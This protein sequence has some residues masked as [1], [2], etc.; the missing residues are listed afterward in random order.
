MQHG[1]D[2]ANRVTAL[3]YPDGEVV[4]QYY[5]DLFNRSGEFMAADTSL[6]DNIVIDTSYQLPSGSP[7]SITFGN[8]YTTTY[9]DDPLYRLS[10][11]KTAIG[12]TTVQDLT[13]AYQANGNVQSINDAVAS[14]N[15]S[16]SYDDLDRLTGATGYT[17]GFT[18]SYS[19]N[20]IGNLLTAGKLVDALLSERRQPAPCGDVG[21]HRGRSDVRH[22]HA[23]AQPELRHQ[24]RPRRQ[25]RRRTRLRRRGPPDR[26]A[27][28]DGCDA[29]DGGLP[30]RRS[31][32]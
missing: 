26:G 1:Y 30:L 13:Y 29:T 24:R 3:T 21:I 7:S 5:D 18:A 11:I 10:R 8:E 19:Y 28:L 23:V 14:E 4:S 2:A 17:G 15:V 12:A 16:Y 32:R 27:R 9:T 20:T 6:G 25:R 22:R 31:E